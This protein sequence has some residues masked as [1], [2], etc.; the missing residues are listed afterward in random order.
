MGSPRPVAGEAL[1]MNGILEGLAG[2]DFPAVLQVTREV[3]SA[4]V[5]TSAEER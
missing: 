4:P 3:G 2:L 5:R 1:L